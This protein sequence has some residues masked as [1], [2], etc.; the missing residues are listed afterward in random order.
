[1]T[2]QTEYKL[3]NV[4]LVKC[5]FER[6]G[7]VH[8]DKEKTEQNLDV[9]ISFNSQKEGVLYIELKVQYWAGIQENEKAVEAEI[10]MG[11]AFKYEGEPN[12]PL[13]VFG[14]I[15]G[16]AI[17]FPFVREQLA[18]LTMKAGLNTVLLPP[19]NFVKLAEERK[20]NTNQ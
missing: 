9:E 3:L 19:V 11:G 6:S 16:P 14:E 13:N 10:I 15:N 7:S 18:N 1:M 2:N 20:K 5:N 17:L 4:V 8:F 12:P